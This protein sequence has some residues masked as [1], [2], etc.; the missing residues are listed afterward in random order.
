MAEIAKARLE[1]IDR[2]VARREGK[3]AEN[4]AQAF[5]DAQDAE[6][7]ANSERDD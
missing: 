5:L 7:A 3:L 2:I 1:R 4:S 6:G